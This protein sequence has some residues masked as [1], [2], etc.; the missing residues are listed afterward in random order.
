[1]RLL[2]MVLIFFSVRVAN[3]QDAPHDSSKKIM[4]F[5]SSQVDGMRKKHIATCKSASVG[6]PSFADTCTQLYLDMISRWQEKYSDPKVTA[7]VWNDCYDSSG[8]RYSNDVTGWVQCVI[9]TQY[10]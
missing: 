8:A 6:A 10:R 9:R 4:P 2:I 5:T 1:M 3:A 7:K